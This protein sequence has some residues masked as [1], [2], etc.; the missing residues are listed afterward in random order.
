MAHIIFIINDLFSVRNAVI[1]MS[2]RLR[3]ANHQ[4]TIASVRQQRHHI[5]AYDIP[6]V[7]LDTLGTFQNHRPLVQQWLQ[8]NQRLDEA[9][10]ALGITSAV[11]RIQAL[12]PDLLVIEAELPEHVI[13]L[14]QLNIPLATIGPFPNIYKLPKMPPLHHYIVPDEGD[15]GTAEH[16]RRV[17]WEYHWIVIKSEIKYFLQSAG[18][19]RL[20]ILRRLAKHVGFDFHKNASIFHWMR[21]ITFTGLTYL[22]THALEFDFPHQP[23]EKVQHMGALLNENRADA[24]GDPQQAEQLETV[25]NHASQQA[26]QR[27][28]YCAFGSL[29]TGDDSNFIERLLEAVKHRSDWTV[30]ISMGARREDAYTDIPEHVHI[31]SWVNQLRVLQDADVIVTHGGIS[32][33]M[34]CLAYGVPMLSYPFPVNDQF[35]TASRIH[36]HRLGI[37][38]QRDTD[39]P[40]TIRGYIEQ[41]LN[42]PL[43][44]ENVA[45]MQDALTTYSHEHTVRVFEDLLKQ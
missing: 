27:I 7:Q 25:L 14:S 19:Y 42:N 45:K 18:V 10:E 8:I 28:I 12:D 38:G 33:V 30:I 32:T 6:Y 35:G 21:P 41:L 3:R 44:R 13:A 39:S 43:Y 11:E 40:E 9:V 2:K 15:D 29:F 34:E 36:Y 17:W 20:S 31:F 23:P 5:E 22:Y 24:I 1:E 4:V 26:N 37:V 16:I